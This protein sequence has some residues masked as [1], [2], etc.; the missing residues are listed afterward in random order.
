MRHR[1]VGRGKRGPTAGGVRE[2]R[3]DLDYC[4]QR[5]SGRVGRGQRGP[6]SPPCTTCYT[7]RLHD[8]QAPSPPHLQCNR[9]HHARRALRYYCTRT[10]SLLHNNPAFTASEARVYRPVCLAFRICALLPSV[11]TVLEAHIYR[12]GSSTLLQ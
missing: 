12:F 9:M 6:T 2:R 3:M 1:R 8:L 11:F 5:N 4:D 10:W 7:G